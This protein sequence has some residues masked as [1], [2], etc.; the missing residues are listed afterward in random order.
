MSS[1]NSKYYAKSLKRNTVKSKNIKDLFS[2]K[3][4]TEEEDQNQD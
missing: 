2:K 1:H 4:K 3:N